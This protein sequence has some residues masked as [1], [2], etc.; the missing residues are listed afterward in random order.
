MSLLVLGLEHLS[1]IIEQDI[2]ILSSLLI[3]VNI[4]FKIV[5]HIDEG[6]LH[7][8]EMKDRYQGMKLK[9]H[10]EKYQ[11]IVDDLIKILDGNS[12]RVYNR[13]HFEFLFHKIMNLYR[14]QVSKI[15]AMITNLATNHDILDS[16]IQRL[17][18]LE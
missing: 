15:K 9:S 5:H 16:P 1:F 8:N 18:P 14:E 11:S 17:D 10:D 12:D 3:K 13:V 7:I 6:Y 4:S 2:E